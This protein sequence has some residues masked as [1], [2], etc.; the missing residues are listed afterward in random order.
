MWGL[1]AFAA[2][3][4]ALMAL[5]EARKKQLAAEGL[6]DDSRKR[7]LPFL[8]RVVGIIRHR[9]RYAEF[10]GVLLPLFAGLGDTLLILAR[11]LCHE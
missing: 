2:G 7:P 9:A 11:E 5:L 10:P 8:P 6:F 4:G 1:A 3:V